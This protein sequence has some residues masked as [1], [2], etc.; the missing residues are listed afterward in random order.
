MVKGSDVVEARE[1]S[2]SRWHGVILA[3]SM[4]HKHFVSMIR[5]SQLPD[6]SPLIPTFRQ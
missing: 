3:R 2:I 6:Q 1:N 4:P 5:H